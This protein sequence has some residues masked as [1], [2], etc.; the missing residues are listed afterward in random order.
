MD[1]VINRLGMMIEGWDGW[2]DMGAQVSGRGHELKVAFVQ[3]CL[4]NQEH[5]FPLLLYHDICRPHNEV[6]G[7]KICDALQGLNGARGNYHA[8]GKERS[9]RPC[10]ANDNPFFPA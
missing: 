4:P 2:Q 9:A 7:V 3:R 5:Q 6:I 1:K 10:D 8:I